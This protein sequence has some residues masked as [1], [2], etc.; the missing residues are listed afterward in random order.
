LSKKKRQS[1]KDLLFN[2]KKIHGSSLDD[3]LSIFKKLD[4]YEG[5]KKLK[6]F[7]S[8]DSMLDQVELL[9]MLSM[10]VKD[11]NTARSKKSK[12]NEETKTN[13]RKPQEPLLKEDTKKAKTE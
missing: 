3:K 12:S 11:M 7:L 9:A 5:F 13:K 10:I 4:S 8:G 6:S 1:A 2:I